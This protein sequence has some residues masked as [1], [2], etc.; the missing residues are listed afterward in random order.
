MQ[1]NMHQ[2]KSQLSQLVDL[3]ASGEEVIIAKSGKPVVKLVPVTN[4]SKREFG[5]LKGQFE[6]SEDFDSQDLSDELA[7]MFGL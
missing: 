4:E 3:A 5:Q 7:D 6:M 1:A 2:A